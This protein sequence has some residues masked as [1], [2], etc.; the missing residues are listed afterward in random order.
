MF[1]FGI[2]HSTFTGCGGDCKA[3]DSFFSLLQQTSTKHRI[4]ASTQS[5]PAHMNISDYQLILV[6]ANIQFNILHRSQYNISADPVFGNLGISKIDFRDIFRPRK[7]KNWAF[8]GQKN[9]IREKIGPF[10]LEISWQNLTINILL[11]VSSTNEK[12]KMGT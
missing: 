5:Q 2:V 6:S 12:L 3:A 7:C 8:L 11:S 1:T 4:A 9:N 10:N